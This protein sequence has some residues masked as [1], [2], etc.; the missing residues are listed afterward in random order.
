MVTISRISKKI[1]SHNIENP[2]SLSSFEYFFNPCFYI[3]LNPI[4]SCNWLSLSPNQPKLKS[5]WGLRCLFNIHHSVKFCDSRASYAV[6]TYSP[7]VIRSIPGV[8]TRVFVKVRVEM[9]RYAI[10]FATVLACRLSI[11]LVCLVFQ[12]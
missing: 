6:R 7:S 4:S 10:Y 9:H 12:Q 3:F 8:S 5:S 1:Y 2:S 11:M